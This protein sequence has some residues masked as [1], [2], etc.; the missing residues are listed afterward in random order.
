MNSVTSTEIVWAV[1]GAGDVCEVKSA[2]AL[3]QLEGSR[4]KTV[5]RRDANKAEDYAQ[6]HGIPF[7]TTDIN[8]VMSDVEINAVYIA[9]PPSTHA[10]YT[11]LA[12][13]AGKTVYAEKPMAD[14]YA[15]CIDMIDCC[16]AE[17]VLLFTAYYRRSLPGFLKVKELVDNE[18]IGELRTVNIEMY[19]P[20]DTKIIKDTNW[21]VD[22]SIA[23]GGYFYDLAS[24]QLDFLDFIFGKISEVK[25][26]SSNQSALYL[27]DDVTSASFKFQNGVVGSGLWCF[28]T[29]QTAAKDLTTIVGNKGTISFNTFGNPMVIKLSTDNQ[30]DHFFEF[31]H[32]Q[33]IQELHIQSILN[34]LSGK[35]ICP[36][37]GISAART[38]WVLEQITK[39]AK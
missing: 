19:Q 25:G 18:I 36:S 3:N 15:A 6:R 34:Q 5:M 23:G 4:I 22:P 30:A 24:H 7:F 11:F 27:A 31:N 13:R 38:S 8:E 35:G 39:G 32:T 9:T 33:P 29:A 16:K 17:N 14:T 21:R 2:P 20:A 37:D 1:I 12:A 28:T 10:Y 26:I